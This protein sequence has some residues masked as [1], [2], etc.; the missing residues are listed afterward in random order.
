MKN[1]R[2]K[3]EEVLNKLPDHPGVYL[4][5][6]QKELIYVGKATSLANR[7][8]SYWSGQ[9][10]FRPIEEM[11]HEVSDIKWEETDSVLEAVILEAIYIKK[12]QPRY[13]VLGKDDKSWNY[14]LL[15][16]DIYPKLIIQREREVRQ[17]GE[18]ELHQKY[19]FVFGP[20]PG[21]NAREVL[22]ILRKLFFISTCEPGQKRPCLYYEMGQCLGVCVGEISAVDYKNKVI[23]PLV[24]FLRGEKKKLIKS[25]EKEMQREAASENFEEA[26]RLR[27]QLQSLERIQD[28][29]LLNKSFVSDIDKTPHPTL[30]SER[31]GQLRIEG[32]DISN[33]GVSGKVGS[34][35]VF[36]EIEPLKSAYRKFK[37][38]TV[39]GQ[40]DVDCLAEILERRLKHTEWP[41]PDV[42]LVDGG[43][44]QVN[45]ATRILREQGV[46]VPVVGIAKGPLRKKNEFFVRAGNNE[47]FGVWFKNNKKLLIQVRDEAHRFAINFQRQQR[48]VL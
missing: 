47:Q 1:L 38:K 28:V 23:K 22:K 13:N 26:S 10:T 43:L 18:V 3:L 6:R 17:L 48:K 46:N 39:V 31:R 42:L 45:R 9:K 2:T 40:S 36:D 29:A 34:M 11:I 16:K 15:S 24:T 25:L 32:Y 33:L 19:S 37:I 8:K 4:F 7:V 21:L 44:P 41:F 27:N 5:Y 30:S 14:L 35:V 20:Y 12:Y